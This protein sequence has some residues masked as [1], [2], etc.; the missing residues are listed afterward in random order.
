MQAYDQVG[1]LTA[2]SIKTEQAYMLLSADCDLLDELGI[3]FER[4]FNM[5]PDDVM[6]EMRQSAAVIVAYDTIEEAQD[7]FLA[8]EAASKEIPNIEL[9]AVVFYKGH[10]LLGLA[11]DKHVNLAPHEYTST[12]MM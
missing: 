2:V 9:V 1:F 3:R 11:Q 4:A 12:L 5:L 8:M 10:S 6:E 7:M